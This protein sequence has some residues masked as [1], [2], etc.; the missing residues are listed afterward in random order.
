MQPVIVA[1]A[2]SPVLGYHWRLT[3]AEPTRALNVSRLSRLK[4]QLGKGLFQNR[5]GAA[6][7]AYVIACCSTRLFTSTFIAFQFKLFYNWIPING[8]DMNSLDNDERIREVN[9][10]TLFFA[11]HECPSAKWKSSAVCTV[12]ILFNAPTPSN[13][14]QHATAVCCAYI[15]IIYCCLNAPLCECCV[16]WI[17]SP[18]G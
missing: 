4:S 2:N 14:T 10:L 13:R 6:A 11:N 12:H 9:S 8:F 16:Y 15:Q 1:E 7:W 17:T 18:Y 5:L 3:S